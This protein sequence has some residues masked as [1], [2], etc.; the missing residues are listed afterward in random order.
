[1]KRSYGFYIRYNYI[2]KQQTWHQNY[3]HR[4]RHRD[5]TDDDW[6]LG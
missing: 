6:T 3:D 4:N 5:I 1:M 2:H